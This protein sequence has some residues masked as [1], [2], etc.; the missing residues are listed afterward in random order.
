MTFLPLTAGIVQLAHFA[1]FNDADVRRIDC[2]NGSARVDRSTII[3]VRATVSAQGLLGASIFGRCETAGH[4]LSR[5]A[6][7]VHRCS[8]FVRVA[9]DTCAFGDPE[10]WRVINPHLFER[11]TSLVAE[12]SS[13]WLLLHGRPRIY[14]PWLGDCSDVLLD[15][16]AAAFRA[17]RDLGL[18]RFLRLS[19]EVE[20]VGARSSHVDCHHFVLV[21]L[22]LELIGVAELLALS[23]V[24]GGARET[25]LQD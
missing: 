1:D 15:V 3:E 24:K 2:R 20:E 13:R 14:H 22:L 23:E 7:A 6:F 19:V 11:T 4:S 21:F 10:I 18:I 17:G 12:A 16:G 25:L 9:L 5:V 8:A